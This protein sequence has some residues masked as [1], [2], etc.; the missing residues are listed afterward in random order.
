[1][2]SRH[3]AAE[4]VQLRGQTGSAYRVHHDVAVVPETL[5]AARRSTGHVGAPA[6]WLASAVARIGSA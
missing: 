6:S 2:T 5:P 3:L 4:S 1:M